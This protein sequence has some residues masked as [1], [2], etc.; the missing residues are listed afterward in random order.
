MES[1]VLAHWVGAFGETFNL[2]GAVVCA[3]DLLRRR[4]EQRALES[5]E[6]L[7]EFV[8]RHKLKGTIYKGLNPEDPHFSHKLAA[9][10][11][12]RMGVTGIALLVVG[13]VLLVTYHA[14][15][16]VGATPH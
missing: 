12:T 3:L 14:I 15:E 10:S 2:A 7:A 4:E 11:A 9:R 6:T 8:R 5:A 1:S 16:I 13:F